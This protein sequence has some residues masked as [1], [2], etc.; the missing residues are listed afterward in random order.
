MSALGVVTRGLQAFQRQFPHIDAE[1]LEL[2]AES[3]ATGAAEEEAVAA[4]AEMQREALEASGQGARAQL[5][6][7]GCV[8]ERVPEPGSETGVLIAS[9]EGGSDPPRCGTVLLL[10]GLDDCL[11]SPMSV[12]E[13]VAAMAIPSGEVLCLEQHS[14][15]TCF[16]IC[17]YGMHELRL[18]V[19]GDHVLRCRFMASSH[20]G[21]FAQALDH[22]NDS[23]D[24]VWD[25]NWTEELEEATM[26]LL[27]A[28]DTHF[29]SME[30][31]LMR[32]PMGSTLMSEIG[33]S[34][35]R[36]ESSLAK[37]LE[38]H[39]AQSVGRV[40]GAVRSLL[41]SQGLLDMF[42]PMLGGG[43]GPLQDS[44]LYR[45]V[46]AFEKARHAAASASKR[47]EVKAALSNLISTADAYLA[48]LGP[49]QSGDFARRWHGELRNTLVQMRDDP[50]AVI[51]PM[52]FQQLR[53]EGGGYIADMMKSMVD[54]FAGQ[55]GKVQ[56]AETIEG[57]MA[58]SP[59]ASFSEAQDRVTR[60]AESL[61]DDA[62]SF[63]SPMAPFEV[64]GQEPWVHSVMAAMG[65]LLSLGFGYVTQGADGAPTSKLAALLDRDR[66][67][68]PLD[69]AEEFL[70]ERR[71]RDRLKDVGRVV[72]AAR[73]R[74]QRL[75][76]TVNTDFQG[77]LRALREH[78]S[79][80]WIGPSLEAVWEKM[81]AAKRVCA[82]ELWL[83]SEDA[84]ASS[85]GAAAASAA[86]SG[87][88][89]GEKP[90][91][92]AADFGHPHTYGQ[93]YYVATRFFDRDFRHLQPG[94]ILAFAEAECLRR[95]GF[96][97]WDLGGADKSPMMQYK[98]QV[99]VE[100]DRSDFLRR[101]RERARAAE[102]EAN[103]KSGGE[104]NQKV[105]GHQAA[106]LSDPQAAPPDGGG[107]IPTGVV[108]ADIT[109]DELW[110]IAE[111]RAREESVRCAD[112]AAK[113]AA[114]KI[115]KPAKAARKVAK[116]VSV[117]HIGLHAQQAPS[118]V[119][120]A[121]NAGSGLSTAK[122]EG[123]KALTERSPAEAKEIAKQRFMAV[124]Q[125]LLA[126]GVSQQDAAAR[127]LQ[128]VT[129][130]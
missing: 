2:F 80:N 6:T 64:H 1:A 3:T 4:L 126:E 111:L 21:D 122:A 117:E 95:A 105:G 43:A 99:A 89:S 44:A 28:L 30:A 22:F 62:I 45:C 46:I 47:V 96:A 26:E 14:G 78:H 115:Q 25:G 16:R 63:G 7:R 52:P 5:S 33:P 88:S 129:S 104:P 60:W 65:S 114:K 17:E 106:Q 20:L 97:F 29:E 130:R 69:G 84:G 82:F 67:A 70:G 85:G 53:G 112:D 58:L 37:A 68:L 31:M 36:L 109:E 113:K 102:L 94:F 127:A 107:R 83:Y 35:R 8:I 90:R 92:V 12:E 10:E 86:S 48:E 34:K 56:R 81:V 91:L 100:M 124:F 54:S 72:R 15:K 19:Q 73:K 79:D 118:A 87:P 18:R 120:K 74:G 38:G 71:R 59:Q 55:G 101:L 24:W 125:Q 116:P 76:L 61:V 42:G 41:T 23:C 39:D 128:A 121:E 32:N 77:T 123:V 11:G 40:Y 66:A 49:G 103:N 98:P 108:F 51:H 9:F 110:G 57:I 13:P 27:A 50:R 93:A 75:R 119:G